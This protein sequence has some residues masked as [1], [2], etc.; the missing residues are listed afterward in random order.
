MPK[1]WVQQK[2]DIRTAINAGRKPRL[3]PDGRQI[4]STVGR[5]SY[6]LLT[7]PNGALTRVGQFYFQT[8]DRMRPNASYDPEQ[9]LTRRGPTDLIRMRSGQLRAVRSLQPTG[10]Y[11]LTTLGKTFFRNRPPV[12]IVAHIPVLVT[13]V[14]Q[15]GSRTGEPYSREDFIPANVAGLGSSF[16]VNEGLSSQDQA[17]EIKAS[18]L[19]QWPAIATEKSRIVLHQESDETYLYDRDR[20]WKLSSMTTRVLND[21]IVTETRLR[22]PLGVL[23]S[24]CIHLPY[25]ELILP[26]AFEELDDHLCVPR[27]LAILMKQRLEEVCECFDNICEDP[28]WRQK[29]VSPE[30]VIKFCVFHSAPCFYL[31]GG[32]IVASYEPPNKEN[33]AVAF[34]SFETHAF[35]Y[36]NARP[37]AAMKG[38]RPEVVAK[39]TK[40]SL[41]L[42]ETWQEWAHE[43]K[44][45]YFVADDLMKVRR[46][47]LESGRNPKVSLRNLAAYSQ[48]SYMC[49]RKK[50]NEQGACVVRERP[51]DHEA[52]IDWLS[53][54]PIDVDYR[55]ERLAAITHKV[56]LQ[57]LKPE[58]TWLDSSQKAA[59]VKRQDGRCAI[60][61]GIFDGDVEYDHISTL[62]STIKGVEQVFQAICS[63]CHSTKTQLE[64]KQDAGLVSYFNRRAFK[65]YVE[66]PRMPPLVYEVHS[67]DRSK[68]YIGLDAV[69]CRKSALAHS[70]FD[71]PV[72][73]PY[74]SITAASA[75]ELG[76]LSF[77]HLRSRKSA[78]NLL[79]GMH[80]TTWLPK[81]VVA[82]LLERREITWDDIKWTLTAS[83]HIPK[84]AFK[85]VLDIMEEA[86][87]WENAHMAKLSI[88]SMVGL[89]ARSD[90]M[91]YAVRSSHNQMDGIGATMSQFFCYENATKTIHDFIW[92]KSVI[93][94][95]SCRPVHDQILG[96]EYILMA[97]I[98]HLTANIDNRFVRQIKTDCVLYQDVP[99]KHRK[100]LQRV[101][102]E[103]TY[104]DGSPM[105]RFLAEGELTPLLVND[106]ERLPMA[107]SEPEPLR[108]WQTIAEG[109]LE[110]HVLSGQ[111]VLITGMP[112]TGKTFRARSLIARLRAEGKIVEV[113]S[114][115]HASVAN[116]GAN[117]HARTADYFTR[118][119]IKNG[120]TRCNV[121]FIE[122]VTMIDVYLW[123]ELGKL[124]Y[125]GVQ[126]ILLGDFKQLPPI[127]PRWSCSP[128]ADDALQR[129]DLVL[130]LAGANRTELKVNMRS[131]P[132]IF[133]FI[134]GLKIDEPDEVP[135]HL[136][137]AQAKA[138]FP[139]TGQRADY[140][141]VMSHRRRIELNAWQNQLDRVDRAAGGETDAVEIKVTTKIQLDNNRPQNMWIWPGQRLVGAGNKVPKGCFVT[142]QSA[143]EDKVVLDTGLS[144]SHQHCSTSL[145]L[146]HA[147]TFA[148]CQ[149]LT[150]RGR[151]LLETK[152]GHL[153]SRHL[154]VGI[155]RGTRHDLVEVV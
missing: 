50:D 108:K 96:H 79:P 119:F 87:S 10:S 72:F 109:D 44:P 127:N 143:D 139:A 122:E 51:E 77:V 32:R 103:V 4:I 67:S 130:E 80:G 104:E 36:S 106:S 11:R 31:A 55:G 148:S 3:L 75:G 57:M 154:Y 19:C 48:V 71:F 34:T 46:E 49:T 155:S 74:D 124:H 138:L 112:G 26:E 140:T 94:N 99:L 63:S 21:E 97:K 86:W 121:L 145:R 9:P 41:P 52:I 146:C 149:G 133:E 116:L 15:R 150:L 1:S 95:A 88:N 59:L 47:M 129:S 27:Q 91:V 132:T 56:F 23:R 105:Y 40:T 8:T 18:V 66:S 54:L 110:A 78:W 84:T 20:D 24:A 89:L 12:E 100:T 64:S 68:P 22:R 117:A 142:V 53:R 114:K 13:G 73:C 125:S 29:G 70:D 33:R 107:S 65:S 102:E 147:L 141:L 5:G 128:L 30:E 92:A 81:N 6:A 17:R 137:V 35:F 39:A 37:I 135:V 118:R 62:K 136:A 153:T 7:R 101:A 144:L 98:R 14:R 76:D 83:G 82:W 90:S 25:H 85:E 151:V 60:C 93:D 38:T 120:A 111:S 2:Q 58:R 61:T 69:R 131:D 126:T 113:V 123:A 115:T 43:Y 28:E 152:S 42:Y 16:S 134:R 45:G